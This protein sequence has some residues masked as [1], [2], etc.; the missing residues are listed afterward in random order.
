MD[1]DCSPLD[2]GFDI[3][4][5]FDF[6]KI[7]T[8]GSELNILKGGKESMKHAFGL[9]LEVELKSV[10]QDQ[11]LLGE[12]TS[13]C[14]ENNFEFIDFIRLSRWERTRFTGLG[15]LSFGDA[16]FL[17][18]PEYISTRLFNKELQEEDILKYALI[19]L[20]YRRIDLLEAL[21]TL[22][23][24]YQNETLKK[25]ISEITGCAKKE[26]KSQLF[27]INFFNKVLNLIFEQPITCHL[28]Y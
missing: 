14:E 12:V 19:L 3:Q 10:Y 24:P 8:Q 23:K 7:D 6:I 18:T 25:Q 15:E 13:F 9:E 20:I 5:K 26:G 28:L 17:K 22:L 1:Y 21:E 16:L 11:P 4:N 2:D 27:L